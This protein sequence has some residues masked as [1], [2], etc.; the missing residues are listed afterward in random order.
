V[1]FSHV[2]VVLR[3][4][5]IKCIEISRD[6][7]QPQNR[8]AIECENRRAGIRK[9]RLFNSSANAAQQRHNVGF[10]HAD[11]I[12]EGGAAATAGRRVSRNHENNTTQNQ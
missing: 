12:F 4:A 5:F 11:G 8:H 6:Q 9:K 2:V 10:V 7:Q 1:Y 3:V